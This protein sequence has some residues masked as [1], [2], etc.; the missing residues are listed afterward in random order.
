MGQLRGMGPL[1]GMGGMG[2]G[3]MGPMGGG[4][5][6]G[7]MGRGGPMGRM[8][9]GGPMGRMGRTDRCETGRMARMAG[10]IPV[11]G[12]PMGMAMR[13]MGMGGKRKSPMAGMMIGRMMGRK[14]MGRA[15]R[16]AKMGKMMP[17]AKMARMGI[18]MG[19][20][21]GMGVMTAG[22]VAGVPGMT[23]RST[24]PGGLHRLRHLL[25]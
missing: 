16:M 24:K 1:P 2:G 3:R 10:A 21:V 14:P 22:R 13:G 12:G 15:A 23:P 7:R 8:A 25:H 18:G 17:A 20:T 6:M 19:K 4:G 9:R 5:L 11:V